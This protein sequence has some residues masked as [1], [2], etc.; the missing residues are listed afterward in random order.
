MSRPAGREE[1]LHR[2]EFLAETDGLLEQSRDAIAGL[3]A[4]GGEPPAAAVNALFRAVH[5]VK[6]LAAMSGFPRLAA[7][8]HELESLLDAMR[9]GR[10]ELSPETL[11]EVGE[12]LEFAGSARWSR[13]GSP[14]GATTGRQKPSSRPKWIGW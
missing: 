5:S 14:P 13:R 12:A 6:G 10:V 4:A 8:A 1:A 9:M 2:K 7:F 11:G 3:G